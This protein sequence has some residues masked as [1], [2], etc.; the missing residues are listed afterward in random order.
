MKILNKKAISV[1]EYSVLFII[2]ITAFV[3]MQNYLQRG[4]NGSWEQSG[5]SFGFGRQYDP[6]RTIE[7]SFDDQSN[8]WYDR[9]CYTFYINN[10]PSTCNGGAPCNGRQSCEECIIT[11]SLCPASSCNDLNKGAAL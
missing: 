8:Q 2:I 7:C 1:I 3:V 10:P 9:N 5:K 4:I 11:S 6:Q